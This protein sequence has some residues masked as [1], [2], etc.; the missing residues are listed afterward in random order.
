MDL[1]SYVLQ[2]MQ[3]VFKKNNKCKQPNHVVSLKLIW[4]LYALLVFSLVVSRDFSLYLLKLIE[5]G[6]H[7]CWVTSL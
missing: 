4:Y 6:K 5:K 2:A 1:Q 7:F 3:F